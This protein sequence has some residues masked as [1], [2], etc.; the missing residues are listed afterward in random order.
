MTLA[1]VNAKIWT[2]DAAHPWAEAL[3]AAGDRLVAVGTNDE[4]KARAG[5]AKVIDAGGRLVTP[6]FIDA[7]V[8]FLEGGA[9]LAS[10]ELRDA[11]TKQVFIDRIRDFAAA[12]ARGRVDHGRQLGSFAVGRRAARQ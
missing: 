9:D 10:V 7:H 2:G 5:G 4:V 1:V 6:G 8:H 3:A 11:A 12:L